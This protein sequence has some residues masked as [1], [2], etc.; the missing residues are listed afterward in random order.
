[1]SKVFPYY[2]TNNEHHQL[3]TRGQALSNG[4]HNSVA[5]PSNPNHDGLTLKDGLAEEQDI[6]RLPINKRRYSMVKDDFLEQGTV[7]RR[8]PHS[9]RSAAKSD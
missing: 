7:G 6:G 9:D 8:E 2:T 4:L 3:V 5:G 1:M